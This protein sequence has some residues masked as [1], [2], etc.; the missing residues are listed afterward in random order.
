MT[1]SQD[2]LEAINALDTS[3]RLGTD[4]V[5]AAFNQM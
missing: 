3:A 1:L 5:E 2:E 4:P